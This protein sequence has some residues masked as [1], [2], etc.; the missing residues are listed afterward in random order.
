M[1][2]V[3]D[4]EQK[5][6]KIKQGSMDVSAY[7][8]KFV[9]LWEEHTNSLEL[10]VCT[11]G[12]CECDAALLWEKL[13]ERGC[14]TKF[15]MGLNEFYDQ[16]RRHV[17]ML[18]LIPTIEETFNIVTQ[19]ERQ[20]L[21]KPVSRI[22]NVVFQSSTHVTLVPENPYVCAYNTACNAQRPVCT[23]CGK[24]GY[25]IQK[26]LKLHGYKNQS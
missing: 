22:D 24:S 21:I 4:I 2:R 5:L 8:T 26:C 13:K 9:T 25:T 1:P 7:Y 23:H 19:D 20:R 14:V 3:I 18:K 17:L 12:K 11:C 16:I 15:L 6:S 10:L